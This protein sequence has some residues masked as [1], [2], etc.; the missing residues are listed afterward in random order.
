MDA[1]IIQQQL[2]KAREKKVTVGNV[3]FTILRPTEMELIRMRS[4]DEGHVEINLRSIKTCVVDWGEMK[5]KYILPNGANDIVPFDKDLF[6]AWIEDNPKYWA[7]LI[8]A[9]GKSVDEHQKQLES[10]EGN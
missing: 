10:T 7:P 3:S 4:G 6:L 2:L 1:R 9:I 5:E 8:E